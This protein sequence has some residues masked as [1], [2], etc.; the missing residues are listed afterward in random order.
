[1]NLWTCGFKA[2][3][4]Y[5]KKDFLTLWVLKNYDKDAELKFLTVLGFWWRVGE[6]SVI[7]K[8]LATGSFTMFHWV[9][10]QQKLDLVFACLWILFFRGSAK[11]GKWN[12]DQ[13][14][15]EGDQGILYKI[16]K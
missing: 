13:M 16:P 10:E 8:G 4:I 5:K 11:M 7:I 12:W 9:Y 14:G 2:P 1:M 6:D 15:S 3:Y